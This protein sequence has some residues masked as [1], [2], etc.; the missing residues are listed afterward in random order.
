MI[1]LLIATTLVFFV[2]TAALI[3]VNRRL[4]RIINFQSKEMQKG[5]ENLREAESCI[6]AAYEQ[7][8]ILHSQLLNYRQTNEVLVNRINSLN[9]RLH[10]SFIKSL[11]P[12]IRRIRFR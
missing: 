3:L 11:E 1:E 5:D 8:N 12:K 7:L 2:S 9:E 10:P 4:N 6:R